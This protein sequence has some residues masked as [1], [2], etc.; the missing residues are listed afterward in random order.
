MTEV[1]VG[2]AGGLPAP[3][4]TRGRHMGQ[5]GS[6]DHSQGWPTCS[7]RTPEAHGLP[8]DIGK[9]LWAGTLAGTLWGPPLAVP[10]DYSSAWA[11]FICG[12]R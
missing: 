5:P 2:A 9:A 6:R 12:A 11:L 8:W 1:T 3:G 4:E 10:Q 7:C